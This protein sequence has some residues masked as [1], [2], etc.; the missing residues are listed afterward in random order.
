MESA[1]RPIRGGEE[2]SINNNPSLAA[3]QNS[4]EN[5]NAIQQMVESEV[6]DTGARLAAEQ[7][8]KVEAKKTEHAQW[9]QDKVD[10]MEGN[11][12][13]PKGKVFPTE[14]L[15]AQPGIKSSVMAAHSDFDPKN[16]LPEKTA[17]EKAAEENNARRSQKDDSWRG[18]SKSVTSKEVTSNFFDNLMKQKEE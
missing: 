1:V 13:I 8:A 17:G 2:T 4:I 11:D 18:N 7:A 5:P 3:N 12:I 14:A 16:D 6:Q 10:A 15:N 9:E